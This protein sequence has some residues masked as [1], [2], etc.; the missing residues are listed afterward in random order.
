MKLSINWQKILLFILAYLFIVG[1]F[2]YVGSLI[3][4][5][6]LNDHSTNQGTPLQVFILTT[7][8]LLGT[9]IT[10]WIFIKYADKTRLIDIGFQKSVYHAP[11]WGFFTGLAVMCTGFLMLLLLHQIAVHPQFRFNFTDVLLTIG[12]C[13][14]IAITEEVL[15]R[16]Y[17]L[18]KLMNHFTKWTALVIS[19][20]LFSL[21]HLF[22]PN[23]GF[24]PIVNLFLAGILLGLPYIFTKNLWFSIAL[25][26]SWNFFQGLLGFN[27]SG[28]NFY[29]VVIQ[30]KS[31]NNVWN[32][33]LFGFEGSVLCLL[34]QIIAILIIYHVFSI[35][36]D[37][38]L[39]N[40]S[41]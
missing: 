36:K 28:L 19:A 33:G 14:G 37:K 34:L 11:L 32:G 23:I 27:V 6:D 25:H 1:L 13:I 29:S 30:N 7:F 20:V 5:I 18:N 10:V 8:G 39:C 4:G 41:S 35:R 26:F 12:T 22:N 24:L 38:P 31:S 15:M 21:M 3:C 17:V 16:G 2:Q 9:L 40:L